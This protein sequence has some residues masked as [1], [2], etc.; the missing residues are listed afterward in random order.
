MSEEIPLKPVSRTDIHKLETALIVATLLREDVL[1]KIRESTERLTWIDSLAV[2]AGALA[3]SRAGMTVEQIAEDLGRSEAT[4]RRHLTGKTEAAKLI[5]ETYQKFLR[6][7]VKLEIPSHLSKTSPE[8]ERRVAELE[9]TVRSLE[10]AKKALEEKLSR[11]RKLAEEL[12][13]ELS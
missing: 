9:S 10:A 3:R 11:A 2:A 8:L 4:I 6:D 13:R 12:V 1:Q 5:E 7:G